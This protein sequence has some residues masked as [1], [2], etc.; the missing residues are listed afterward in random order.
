MYQLI[1]NASKVR[2]VS[3]LRYFL[4]QL[5]NYNILLENNNNNNRNCA[6]LQ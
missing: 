2:F 5:I 4:K 6:T 3:G 1:S